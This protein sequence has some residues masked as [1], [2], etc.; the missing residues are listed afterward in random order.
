MTSPI[1]LAIRGDG[2]M[3]RTLHGHGAP[4]GRIRLVDPAHPATAVLIDL[5]DAERP[6]AVVTAL[7]A[8]AVVLCPPPVAHTAAQLE[9]MVAAARAGGGRLLPAGEIA[10]GAAGHRGLTAIAS[11]DFGALRAM[12][13][14]IRQ[15]RGAGPDVLDALLP[16]ALDAVLSAV[17]GPFVSVRVNAGALFGPVRDTSVIL[18]QSAAGVVVTIE[19]SR[20]LPPTLP[21]CGLGE[22]E[23]DAM[24]AYQAVR[25]VPQTGA[26]RIHRDDATTLAPW[27]DAP[28]LAMLAALEAAI[29]RPDAAPDGLA[30]AEAAL[31]LTARIRDAADQAF[32]TS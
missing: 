29:D 21:A 7:R 14:A 22:V 4:L 27:L 26:V 25:I 9:V 31:T 19:L 23:I 1:S 6:A 30:R 5:P 17:P 8:G 10:H 32:V 2:A 16:E 12:Y 15:P 24:G 13:L 28:V 11:P 18:L 3:A 20:C